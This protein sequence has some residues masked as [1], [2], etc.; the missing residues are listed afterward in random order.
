MKRNYIVET[1]E[2][3][4]RY[5]DEFNAKFEDISPWMPEINRFLRMMPP[6]G[7][8]LDIGSGP[9]SHAKYFKDK[10]YGVTCIDIS[11]EMVRLCRERGLEA[12]VMGVENLDFRTSTFDGVWACTSLLHIPKNHLRSAL[13]QIYRAMMPEGIF[14]LSMKEGTG[15]GFREQDKYPGVRRY[16]SLYSDKKLREV[17]EVFFHIRHKSKIMFDEQHVFLNYIMQRI[18]TAL[19]WDNKRRTI[20]TDPAA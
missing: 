15:E 14:F 16:F 18:G 19:K 7:N 20:V 5:A 11:P 3:Y 13:A 9:G 8:I 10:G 2:A 6:R 1:R 4:D 17:L 12:I